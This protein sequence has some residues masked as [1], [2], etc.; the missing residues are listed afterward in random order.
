MASKGLVGNESFYASSDALAFEQ[1]IKVLFSHFGTVRRI[2]IH[3]EK[4][5]EAEV[6]KQGEQGDRGEWRIV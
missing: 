4:D 6:S 2:M 5:V 3:K 1:S